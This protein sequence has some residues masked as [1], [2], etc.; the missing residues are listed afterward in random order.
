MVCT[1]FGQEQPEILIPLDES[2]TQDEL[3][4]I[5]SS[6]FDSFVL[7]FV[8]EYQS[9]P[10]FSKI[11]TMKN[12]DD[13][14]FWFEEGEE[15]PPDLPHM[16]ELSLGISSVSGLVTVIGEPNELEVLHLEECFDFLFRCHGPGHLPADQMYFRNKDRFWGTD[17][18]LFHLAEYTCPDC[19]E[20]ELSMNEIYKKL[21]KL[22][23][24]S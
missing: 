5:H 24:K 13:I 4:A 14:Q 23:N 19:N 7:A 22:V 11:L 20:M 2:L 10:L 9:Y 21:S 17:R 1:N 16:S 3:Y 6:N 15:L 12:K 18:Y 8:D